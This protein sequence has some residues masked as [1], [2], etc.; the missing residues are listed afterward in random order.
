MESTK[1]DRVRIIVQE[2]SKALPTE[3]KAIVH[4]LLARFYQ[5]LDNAT[6]SDI[7]ALIHLINTKITY[8]ETGE[9]PPA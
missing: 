5:L 7:D 9:R 8:I 4:L 2:F 3:S 6:E 1:K